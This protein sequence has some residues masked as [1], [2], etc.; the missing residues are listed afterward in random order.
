M[1]NCPSLT[2]V[3][4]PAYVSAVPPCCISGVHENGLVSQLIIL[5]HWPT[6][7]SLSQFHTIFIMPCYPDASGFRWLWMLSTCMCG[8]LCEH[9]F[10]DQLGKSLGAWLLDCMAILFSFI[11]DCA[12]SG[13]QFCIPT[14]SDWESL[15]LI[16]TSTWYCQV[17]K[18]F[19]ILIE[20]RWYFIVVLSCIFLMAS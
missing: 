11:R 6:F 15:F 14:C 3:I 16:L 9:E 19:A 2:E 8:F 13:L 4:D 5:F 10:S 18:H 12:Q 1:S 20:V 17:V 7:L